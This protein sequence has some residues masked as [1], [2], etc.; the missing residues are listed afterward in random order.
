MK[1]RKFALFST[2]MILVAFWA[3]MF[4]SVNEVGSQGQQSTVIPSQSETPTLVSTPTPTS[5]PTATATFT[6]EQQAGDLLRTYKEV[7][8]ASK[9]AVE[10]VHTTADKVLGTVQIIFTALTIAGTVGAGIL[11]VFTKLNSDKARDAEQKASAALETVKET[12]KKADELE[13]R[14]NSALSTAVELSQ[15]QDNLL[16]QIKDAAQLLETLQSEISQIKSGG[17]RDRQVIKKPL[18]VMQ[19]DEYAMQ[20]LSDEPDE[21][22]NSILSLIEM[23][24]RNDAKPDAVIRR[25]AVKV[26]GILEEYDE[27]VVKRLKEIIEEDP[28]QGVRKEAEKSLKLIEMNKKNGGPIP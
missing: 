7:L 14:N 19:I 3:L 9:S 21:K 2:S 16:S 23:S 27:R 18:A 8:D 28:A 11:G 5:I 24:R 12:E 13:K 6:L 1:M 4:I 25:K 26:F 20:V 10:E 15:R 17:E 22:N